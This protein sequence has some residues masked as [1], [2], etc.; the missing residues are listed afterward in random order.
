MRVVMNGLAALKPKTGVGH[1]VAQLHRHLARQ[2]P[3]SGFALYPDGA[4]A[5]WL[6]REGATGRARGD[7]GHEAL[8]AGAH[9]I[10]QRRA[11]RLVAHG[12]ELA[13]GLAFGRAGSCAVLGIRSIGGETCW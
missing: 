7:R 2:F 12:C 9:E 1:Y 13:Q 4:L 8:D 6:E 5:T 10:T 11:P 3:G